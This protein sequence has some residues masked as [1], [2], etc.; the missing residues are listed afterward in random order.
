M[1]V[2]VTRFLLTLD[3]PEGKVSLRGGASL[4]LRFLFWASRVVRG[5][6]W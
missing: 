1:G 5:E 2:F 3:R 6:S 4:V